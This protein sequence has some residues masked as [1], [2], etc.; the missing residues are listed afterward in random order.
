MHLL[1]S[2]LHDRMTQTILNDIESAA[3]LFDSADPTPMQSVDILAQGKS[4]LLKANVAMG[5][6]LADE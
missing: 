1:D 3:I 6:A 4:G 2:F 5:L